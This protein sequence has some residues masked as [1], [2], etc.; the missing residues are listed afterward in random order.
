MLRHVTKNTEYIT[1]FSVYI[2]IC[3]VGASNTASI[4]P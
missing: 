2:R 3:V 1:D 4:V